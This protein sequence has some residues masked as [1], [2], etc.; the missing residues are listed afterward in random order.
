[1]KLKFKNKI[2]KIM[3]Y[4]LIFIV[5]ICFLIPV[6]LSM[7]GIWLKYDSKKKICKIFSNPET[8]LA[9]YDEINIVFSRKNEFKFEGEWIYHFITNES[10]PILYSFKPKW[11]EVILFNS[12]DYAPFHIRVIR[13]GHF[14]S[15]YFNIYNEDNMITN[16]NLRNISHNVYW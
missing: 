8:T 1:M 16:I 9:F 13:G 14:T 3:F 6:V 4:S 11:S 15:H 7:Y 2:D 10:F 5:I 12:N